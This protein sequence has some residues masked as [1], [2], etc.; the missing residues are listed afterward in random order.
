MTLQKVLLWKIDPTS[1]LLCKDC[2]DLVFDCQLEEAAIQKWGSLKELEEEKNKRVEKKEK[3]ALEKAKEADQG[4]L[5]AVPNIGQQVVS[6]DYISC[7][8]FKASK[9]LH[10]VRH[11][12]A[13]SVLHC[14]DVEEQELRNGEED[15]RNS[16]TVIKEGRFR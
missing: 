3:K 4:I 13:Q 1:D 6:E 7:S 9:C 15:A 2:V 14:T 12:A 16:D 5:N 10:M 8:G 11:H